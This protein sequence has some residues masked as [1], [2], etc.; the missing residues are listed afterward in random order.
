LRKR[1][2]K[3]ESVKEEK[4]IKPFG[5]TT[6]IS[7]PSIVLKKRNSKHKQNL[8]SVNDSYLLAAD[9]AADREFLSIWKMLNA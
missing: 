5:R 1:R 3:E 2:A 9:G 7:L 6:V 4:E 8:S